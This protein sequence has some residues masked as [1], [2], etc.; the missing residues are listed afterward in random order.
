M[1]SVFY[2]K[3]LDSP[4]CAK[5]LEEKI[6]NINSVRSV[7]ISFAAGKL[8]V[9][10]DDVTQKII[11]TI[12]EQGL[13]IEKVCG[14]DVAVEIEDESGA[15]SSTVSKVK[16]AWMKIFEGGAVS[17][18]ISGVILLTAALMWW[19][20]YSKHFVIAA[21]SAAI[22]I[23]GWATFKKG[24]KNLV[25][26]K[27]DINV[28]MVIALTGAVL[29]GEWMEGAV[30]AFLFSLSHALED[31]AMDR[32]RQAVKKLINLSPS[33]AFVKT[34][35]GEVK[36]DIRE[37]K[38]G[39]IVVVR[40]G[41]RIP[42]DGKV[43]AG[44]SWV[45]ESAV[46]GESQLVAKEKGSYVYAGTINE[47]GYLEILV[48]KPA[49]ESMIS[50]IIKLVEKALEKKTPMQRTVDKFAVYYTPIILTIALG[51]ATIPTFVL[52]YDPTTWVYRSL[53]LLLVACPCALVISTP[54]ALVSAMGRSATAGV[55]VKGGD[56]F[57]K[58]AKVRVL[59]FD[60]TG[61]LTKGEP[62]V[63]GVYNAE[64]VNSEELLKIAYSLELKSEHPL[65]KSLCN[66]AKEKRLEP[67][68]II[69]FK[70]YPGLG[71]EGKLMV[72]SEEIKC[73]LGNIE[74][75]ESKGAFINE[76]F[77]L[78]IDENKKSGRTVIG[79]AACYKSQSIKL[80]GIVVFEDDIRKEAREVI[81]AIKR[82]GISTVMLTGDNKSAAH[83]VASALGIDT[84]YAGLMP[85][86]KLNLIEKMQEEK[87][88]V[89]MVGDGINDAPALAKCDVGIAM[90]AK[91]TDIAL[92]AAD[93]ALLSDDIKKIP[94]FIVLSKKSLSIIKQNIALAVSLKLAAVALLSGG[95][96]TMWMAV[97]ADMGTTLIVILNGLR[98]SRV[99]E[100]NNKQSR[101]K[102]LSV[103]MDSHQ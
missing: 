3:G 31:Y 98:L 88:V 87:G 67:F 96:L 84:V 40:P 13:S 97:L 100:K 82:M 59:A 66:Y 74:F 4:D 45:N 79:V 89:A 14:D 17:A 102:Q 43:L 18:A 11:E 76:K 53:A 47:G 71:V 44:S 56:Y 103:A 58:M 19:A 93:V 64:D 54:V 60:K 85:E 25:R 94:F 52:G 5:K 77:K 2:L 55:L 8:E 34:P 95:F 26:F 90:G 9:E 81:E 51:M 32:T 62:K 78:L 29:I 50:K 99:R 12:R 86:E 70:P 101:V 30:I 6:K 68:E 63:C 20:G 46:T 21:Y 16:N 1:T 75:L 80:I 49:S 91:G 69:S 24:V 22:V 37:V 48:E 61:T 92:E 83:S 33:V 39:E 28:L 10:Y 27:F 15:G 36:K 73:L 38:V 7:K 72:D 57:E 41:E 35:E 23:G 42:I 65:A